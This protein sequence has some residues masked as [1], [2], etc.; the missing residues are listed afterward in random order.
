MH[1]AT[2]PSP[3]PHAGYV[4]KTGTISFQYLVWEAAAFREHFVGAKLGA[5]PLGPCFGG[6]VL[7]TNP[8][9]PPGGSSRF[10]SFGRLFSRLCWS[11]LR[12]LGP[13]EHPLQ[14]NGVS[15][16]FLCA[17]SSGAVPAPLTCLTGTHSSLSR[18]S[19]RQTPAC[20][21]EKRVPKLLL[22][23][24]VEVREVLPTT[25]ALTGFYGS[26]NYARTRVGSALVGADGEQIP[27][28]QN[29][30]LP[31]PC[32]PTPW[33]G[34]HR[35]RAAEAG[36]WIPFRNQGVGPY[37]RVE[38][39][40][41]ATASARV[42]TRV[43]LTWKEADSKKYTLVPL[44][45]LVHSSRL[46]RFLLQRRARFTASPHANNASQKKNTLKRCVRANLA[47]EHRRQ[48]QPQLQ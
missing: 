46:P 36:A 37:R 28:L 2:P 47:I 29:T 10:L 39:A 43:P 40:G 4:Y 20:F 48:A 42:P 11:A 6:G 34:L 8:K 33:T 45:S 3:D 12:G 41:V 9:K 35:A 38:A 30:T 25:G 32:S 44:A 27:G 22:F 21:P 18:H 19:Q 26:K 14:K 23:F 17:C 7:P 24:F 1:R 15:A 31:F 16:G 13:L 5:R